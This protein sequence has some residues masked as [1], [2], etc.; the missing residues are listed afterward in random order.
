MWNW[1]SSVH[2]P[3]Y[4][5]SGSNLIDCGS[6]G[7]IVAARAIRKY[8]KHKKRLSSTRYAVK[9]INISQSLRKGNYEDIDSAIKK[10]KREITIH[11]KMNHNNIVQLYS[12]GYT[13]T[14]TSNPCGTDLIAYI[15]MEYIDGYTLLDYVNRYYET[16][17]EKQ[18]HSYFVQLLDAIEYIHSLGITHRDLKLENIM[19]SKKDQRI[20]IIDFGFSNESHAKNTLLSTF[21]GSPFY[22]APEIWMGAPYVGPM[23]DVWA[24]GIILYS[25]VYGHFPYETNVD[26]YTLSKKVV[27]EEVALPIK[28]G[29]SFNLFRLMSD[30][31]SIDVKNR[32][33]I[34]EIRK[35]SWVSKDP[36]KWDRPGRDSNHKSWIS[37]NP[38]LYNRDSVSPSPRD[39]WVSK[40]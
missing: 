28:S 17:T 7:C 12:W 8:K 25:L 2:I 37:H 39:D 6:F 32:I 24:L 14:K 15:I 11:H 3:G 40:N 22:A 13:S 5:F 36:S 1:I 35:R 10:Y 16:C 9:L 19:I 33:P 29:Y 27:T 38:I 20:V 34:S 31:L 30:M 23:V 18:I 21:C 26:L 4:N